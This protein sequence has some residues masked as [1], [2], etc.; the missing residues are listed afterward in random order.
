MEIKTAVSLLLEQLSCLGF[1][2][3]SASALSWVGSSRPVSSSSVVFQSSSLR[4]YPSH[5][6]ALVKSWM[7]SLQKSAVSISKRSHHLRH[8]TC[9]SFYVSHSRG[10]HHLKTVLCSFLKM[11]TKSPSACL[12]IC[13]WIR[14]QAVGLCN[15]SNC[16]WSRRRKAYTSACFEGCC[17]KQP[18]ETVSWLC[19]A[20]IFITFHSSSLMWTQGRGFPQV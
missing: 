16:S 11:I 12:Q 14:C 10:R 7:P 1:S 20:K 9:S 13:P 18:H 2:A 5:P 4:L 19:A 6:A 3:P 15:R 17:K 8:Q